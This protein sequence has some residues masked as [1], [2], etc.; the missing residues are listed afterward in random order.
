MSNPTDTHYKKSEFQ[1]LAIDSSDIDEAAEK[2]YPKQYA[3]M[4]KPGSTIDLGK[5]LRDAFKAGV[6]WMAGQGYTKEGIARPDDCE[7]WINLTDTDIKDG[8]KVIV[9][10]RKK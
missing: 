6:E 9:Q 1:D 8:D 5:A 2:M 3:Y 7:I 4:P 10:V